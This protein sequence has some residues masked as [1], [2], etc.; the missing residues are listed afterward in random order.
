[1]PFWATRHLLAV[2]DEEERRHANEASEGHAEAARPN[3]REARHTQLALL[4]R[5]G[6]CMKPCADAEGLNALAKADAADIAE[7]VA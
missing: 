6:G 3:L 4:A 7:H 1:V 2:R 5:E